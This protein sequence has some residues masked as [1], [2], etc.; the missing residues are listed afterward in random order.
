[1]GVLLNK[2]RLEGNSFSFASLTPDMPVG[3]ESDG[4]VAISVTQTQQ[5]KFEQKLSCAERDF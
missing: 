4:A 2:S 5:L 1:M 3:S